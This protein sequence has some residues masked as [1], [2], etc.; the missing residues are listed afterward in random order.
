MAHLYTRAACTVFSFDSDTG[1]L[2]RLADGKVTV[3]VEEL[4][5]KALLDA[6]KD[7]SMGA[8]DCSVEITEAADSTA[9][10]SWISKAGGTAAALV[11]TITGGP[12]LSGT[13]GCYG[14]H[15]TLGDAIT[16]G[17]TLKNHGTVTI[18]G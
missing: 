16:A 7:R 8:K 1:L 15:L 14:A 3:D 11:I 4:A 5:N 10:A 2:D 17:G 9:A 18:T 13:F 6:W 12:S